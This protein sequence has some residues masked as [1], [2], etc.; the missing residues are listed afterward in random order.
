MSNYLLN[1]NPP[2][3]M[4]EISADTLLILEDCIHG[5]SVLR[6]SLRERPENKIP[7]T[8]LSH[9]KEKGTVTVRITE[10]DYMKLTLACKA[11]EK[12]RSS[13]L[14]KEETFDLRCVY[15]ETPQSLD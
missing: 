2:L 11:C 14:P 3:P 9:D 10:G 5:H 12:C 1:Q 7:G 4:S 8:Y 13:T 6:I 15:L